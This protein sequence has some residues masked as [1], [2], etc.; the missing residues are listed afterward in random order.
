MKTKNLLFL[1]PVILLFQCTTE[2]SQESKEDG[3]EKTRIVLFD[4]TS[5]DHWKDIKSD[6]FPESGWLISD[7]ILT[8]LAKT[9]EQEGGHDIITKE[10][11]SNFELELEVLLS[12]GANSGVKYMVVDTYP[13]HEGNYL[14]L[15]YQLVDNEKHPE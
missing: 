7:G 11:Y 15:E 14:G 12:E 9:E 8:V 10:Q 4:G 2:T 6:N 13:G 3:V 5:T 1:L